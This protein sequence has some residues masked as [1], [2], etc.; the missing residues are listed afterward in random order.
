M[1]KAMRWK[2]KNSSVLKCLEKTVRRKK[3]TQNKF[4]K[5]WE[6]EVNPGGLAHAH[7]LIISQ[8]WGY[9]MPLARKREKL[10][11]TS[12][13]ELLRR[14]KTGSKEFIYYSTLDREL[15]F[16]LTWHKTTFTFFSKL[17]YSV[18][19]NFLQCFLPLFLP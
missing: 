19:S 15:F 3:S 1:R 16:F 7:G 14:D 17:F 13:A 12:C 4:Q 9:G 11:G 6:L 18:F 2:K 5:V 10:K 8:T